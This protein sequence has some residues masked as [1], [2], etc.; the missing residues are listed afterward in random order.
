MVEPA[1]TTHKQVQQILANELGI[2]R[3]FVRQVIEERVDKLLKAIPIESHIERSVEKTLR[4]MA[5][6]SKYDNNAIRE[7][8]ARV[9]KDFVE[10]RLSVSLKEHI[11]TEG[12]GTW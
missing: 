10:K 8:A 2:D 7:I 11:N 1:I 5:G 4:S 12:A 9:A 6:T 3:A